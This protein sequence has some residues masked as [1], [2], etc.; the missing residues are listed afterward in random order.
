M[1][2]EGMRILNDAKRKDR[3]FMLVLCHIDRIM[4]GTSKTIITKI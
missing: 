2:E 4:I 3:P 1:S